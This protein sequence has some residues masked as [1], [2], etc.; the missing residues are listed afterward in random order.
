M[1][2]FVFAYWH[3]SGDINRGAGGKAGKKMGG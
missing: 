1:S 3:L 2:T